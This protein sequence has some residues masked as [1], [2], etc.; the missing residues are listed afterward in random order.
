LAKDSPSDVFRTL[1]ECDF[2]Y[3]SHNHPDHLHPK[4][5]EHIRKDMPILTAGFITNSAVSILEQIGFTD[6]TVMDFSSRFINEESEFSIA[7]LKSGDFRDDSGLLVEV[8]EFKCLLTVDSNQLNFGKLPAVDLLCSSFSGGAS[9]FPLCFD[10]YSEQEKK[11]IVTRNRRSIRAAKIKDIQ[12]TTPHYFMPYA[13]FFIEKAHRDKYVKENNLKNSV[14][15]YQQICAANKCELLNVNENQIFKFE[16]KEL[17]SHSVDISDRYIDK[18]V[19]DYLSDFRQVCEEEFTRIL[20]AYFEGSDYKD[21]LEL[22]LIATDESFSQRYER[23]NI[24]FNEQKISYIDEKIETEDLKIKALSNGNRFLQIKVRREE[25][26]GIILNR[27]PWEDLSIGFQCRVYRKP[28]VYNSEF[29]YY[30][31]NVYIGKNVED[32]SALLD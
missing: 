11:S 24:N 14:E 2:I 16:G 8:G 12:L 9:G 21:N 17:T 5:L 15:D 23:F 31:T 18:K 7:V 20:T 26:I 27:R 6:I 1:N 10:N 19:D 25:L 30:F 29:W 13:G 4:S 32:F 22:D 3:I 28:N